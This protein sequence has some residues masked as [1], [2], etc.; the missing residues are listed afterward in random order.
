MF[1][2]FKYWN[3]TKTIA[4]TDF[5]LKYQGSV[6]G[7]LW[8]LM[9]PLM[10]FA[11]LYFVFTRLF[12]LGDEIPYYPVYLLLGIVV[13]NFFV[14]STVSALY[15]I[16]GKG[17]LLRKVYFPRIALIISNTGTTFLT[18]IS[19]L[20]IV[21]VFM[22]IN[23]VPFTWRMLVLPL[24][25]IELYIL[26]LGVGLIV[27]SLYVRFR[28]IA[29]IYEVLLQAAFY[30]TPILWS[31]LQRGMSDKMAA[32][33]MMNPMAQILQDFRWA[34]IDPDVYLV[35]DAVAWP[36]VA[37]PYVI[38]ILVFLFGYAFFQR[39]AAKFAEEV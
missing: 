6:L 20:I 3:L 38:P 25:F 27:S 33:V 1:E 8:S 19:S 17:D 5:K 10:L 24:V 9:K 16:V 21:F 32:I 15:S 35:S 39:S 4:L 12:A 31:P 30:A 37:V 14:E 11:V 18:F 23:G 29:H 22:I 36:T 13:W 2:I 28:D 7:F 26:V 34:L